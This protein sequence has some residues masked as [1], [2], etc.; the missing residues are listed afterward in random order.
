L[1]KVK[2]RGEER[3]DREILIMG[4]KISVLRVDAA[5]FIQA[6]SC[7]KEKTAS[8]PSYLTNPKSC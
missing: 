2:Q 4:R 7:Q 3:R 6:L 5:H 1:G 8:E